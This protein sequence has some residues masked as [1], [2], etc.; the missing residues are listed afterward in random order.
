[1]P[2]LRTTQPSLAIS[3]DLPLS[4]WTRDGQLGVLTERLLERVRQH[5]LPVTWA[6]EHPGET[7]AVEDVVCWHGDQE[8][9]LLGDSQW[10]GAE[11]GRT[12]FSQELETRIQTARRAGLGITT[13]ALR[14]TSMN[15][16]LD[17]LVKHRLTVVRGDGLHTPI[18][19]ELVSHAVRF[20]VWQ[21]AEVA[22]IPQSASWWWSSMPRGVTR[23]LRQAQQG[24]PML[25]IVIQADKLCQTRD[26]VQ[27]D[28]VLG[29]L[30][31][32]RD[33]GQIRLG[34]IRQLGQ[35]QRITPSSAT[36]AG[37]IRRTA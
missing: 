20:G 25:Q 22:R 1:M 14:E 8:L 37:S 26:W 11:A 6:V 17:L 10:V 32:L 9:A 31:R 28:A 35:H 23:I 21:A 30:K 18:A 36:L 24:H 12:R 33:R 27:V 2:V 3:V 13:L 4:S 34:T 16:H 15:Q 19:P 5:G 7:S 29:H